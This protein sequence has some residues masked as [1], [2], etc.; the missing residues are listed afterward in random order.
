MRRRHFIQSAAVAT[1]SLPWFLQ[2]SQARDSPISKYMS[3]IGLQLWTV[4]NQLKEDIPG[5]LKAVADA[6]YRQVELGS[7]MDADE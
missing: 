5:T 3:T 4:R 6:G 2:T 7:V 1:I